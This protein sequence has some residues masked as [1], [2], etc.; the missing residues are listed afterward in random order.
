MNSSTCNPR[1]GVYNFLKGNDFFKCKLH[2]LI[3]ATKLVTCFVE[4]Q[5]KELQK[6]QTHLASSIFGL[7]IPLSNFVTPLT[8]PTT[9]TPMC[10]S[11]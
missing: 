6:L 5:C 9:T 4:G 7:S 1:Y 3:H 10:W 11:S 2:G 8:S